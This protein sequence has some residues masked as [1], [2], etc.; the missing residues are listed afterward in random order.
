MTV[1]LIELCTLKHFS[2]TWCLSLTFTKLKSTKQSITKVGNN[3]QWVIPSCKMCL[4]TLS[5]KHI[6]D[7]TKNKGKMQ[8]LSIILKTT[9]EKFWQKHNVQTDDIHL[10]TIHNKTNRHLLVEVI[11]FKWQILQNL[12]LSLHDCNRQ[13]TPE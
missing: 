10:M 11:A 8:D 5:A 1:K 3:H 7:A 13:L 2:I 6:V 12:Q 9:K 4:M